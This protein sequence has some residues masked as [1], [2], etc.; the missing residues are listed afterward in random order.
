MAGFL[1]TRKCQ[2]ALKIRRYLPLPLN[3]PNNIGFDGPLTMEYS[4]VNAL[5]IRLHAS[6]WREAERCT[7]YRSLYTTLIAL[8]FHFIDND[9]A[10]CNN[11]D[12]GSYLPQSTEFSDKLTTNLYQTLMTPVV[13]GVQSNPKRFTRQSHF[14]HVGGNNNGKSLLKFN[15]MAAMTQCAY[16]NHSLPHKGVI[17]I[18]IITTTTVS[19]PTYLKGGDS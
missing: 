15:N 19:E 10:C 5:T 1:P 12:H 2:A 18:I 9:N 11:K 16:Q 3:R 13:T 6:L 4:Q 17:I 7:Y 14:S 8:N